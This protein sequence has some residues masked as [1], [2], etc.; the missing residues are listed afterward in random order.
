MLCYVKKTTTLNYKTLY[1]NIYYHHFTDDII[2]MI[3]MEC[4]YKLSYCH[5]LFLMSS[6]RSVVENCPTWRL[7]I[8]W[9][10]ITSSSLRLFITLAA[11]RRWVGRTFVPHIRLT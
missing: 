2:Y 3:Q 8:C 1:R 7:T 6:A 4:V 9:R 10:S 5:L 11:L